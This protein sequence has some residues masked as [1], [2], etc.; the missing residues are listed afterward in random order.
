VTSNGWAAFKVI[1]GIV[2]KSA[3]KIGHRN[4]SVSEVLGGMTAAVRKTV[5][6]PWV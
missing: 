5:S 3:I 1:D 2:A 4:A 6:Q